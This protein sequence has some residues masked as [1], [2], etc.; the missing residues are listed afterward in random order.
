MDFDSTNSLHKLL[1][2]LVIF[3]PSLTIFGHVRRQRLTANLASPS[4]HR[5]VFGMLFMKLNAIA[6]AGTLFVALPAHA[7]LEFFGLTTV[8]WGFSGA[9]IGVQGM[10]IE[11]FEDTALAPGLRIRWSAP[12]G[13]V[14]PTDTLPNTFDPTI[15]DPFGNAFASG[16]WTGSRV[17]VN[18]RTN[19]P[20]PYNA[21]ENWDDVELL[22][23]PPVASVGFSVQQMN[24]SNS[25][26]VNGVVRGN[27]ASLTGLPVGS[28]RQGYVIIN[29]TNGETISSIRIDSLFGDGFVIDH[30]AFSTV[31]APKLTITSVSPSQWGV[32]NGS[33][34][35]ASATVEDFEDPMLQADLQVE[36]E[37][38]LGSTPPT[39]ILPTL[40]APVT[41]D[42]FGNAFDMSVWDG[43]RVVINTRDNQSHPYAEIGNWG[44]I[45]FHFSSPFTHIGVAMGDLSLPAFVVANGRLTSTLASVPL[46][47][48]Q[49]FVRFASPTGLSSI[50]VL[51]G[52]FA[53]ND[54]I[55][56][57]HLCYMNC[58]VDLN[59]DTVVNSQDFFDFLSSFFALEPAA[60]FNRDSF[61][62][63][64]DFF[65][66][67]TSFFIGC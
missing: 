40:F 53:F 16:Q 37:T 20:F 64:Q 15:D 58:N 47:S 67:L 34:G 29:A 23:D 13:E 5:S 63:S 26:V 44:D 22:F 25:V 66:F 57:D 62:N 56:F 9:S 32:S 51:N 48:R 1:T 19:R 55:G 24:V 60:D 61:I 6:L 33:L 46:G 18:T 43:S 7:D 8:R 3:T 11:D 65:D 49:G 41:D 17:L 59:A 31:P 14:G 42:P 21:S 30:L 52:R 39:S 45:A 27:F 28:D 4:T 35:F 50:R 54:G 12:A 38:P 2:L 36:W 10:T